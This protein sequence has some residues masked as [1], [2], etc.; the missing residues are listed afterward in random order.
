MNDNL[1]TDNLRLWHGDCIELMKNIPDNSVDMIMFDAPFYQNTF[2]YKKSD[3]KDKM[4]KYVKWIELVCN[5]FDR[6]L[7]EGGNICYLNAPKYIYYTI[8][9]FLKHFEYRNDIPLIRQGSFRPAYMLGFQHNILLMLYKK[10]KKIKW[11][12]PIKNHDKSFP[13]DVWS[14]IKYRNGYRGKGKNNW[15]PEA[16]GLDITERCITLNS[17][18]GDLVLDCCSGSMTTAIASINTGR[19]CICIEK[20]DHYFEVGSQ[21]VKNYLQEK[22]LNL[23]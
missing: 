5:E 13:T 9:V 19:R 17:N 21:R 20:D 4:D 22:Q 3:K 14:D 12:G 8:N 2:P 16:I 10:D 23:F 15:H 7:A 6:V 1:V 18:K 11:N